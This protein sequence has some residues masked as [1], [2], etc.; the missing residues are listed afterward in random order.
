MTKYNGFRTHTKTPHTTGPGGPA[1]PVAPGRPCSPYK[2]ENEKYDCVPYIH[3]THFCNLYIFK[4][5]ESH[6]RVQ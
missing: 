1:C 2:A 4:A 5:I 6:Q 3:I